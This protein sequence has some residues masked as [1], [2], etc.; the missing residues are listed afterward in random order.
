VWRGAG[1]LQAR[2]EG[3]LGAVLAWDRERAREEL[4][5]GRR[6]EACARADAEAR[7][8]EGRREKAA[9]RLRA[10]QR[11]VIAEA[12]IAEAGARAA[13]TRLDRLAE[14]LAAALEQDRYVFLRTTGER[15]RP[16]QDRPALA[17]VPPERLGAAG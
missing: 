14:G 6:V 3:A 17:R 12:R 1:A 15:A 16:A 4:E 7:A 5:R 11:E 2:R 9:A 10:L 8:A 13:A